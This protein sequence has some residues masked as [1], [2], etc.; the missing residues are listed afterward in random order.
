MG[1]LSGPPAKRGN[2]WTVRRL[3]GLE[4]LEWT[5]VSCTLRPP[6]MDSLPPRSYSGFEIVIPAPLGKICNPDDEDWAEFEGLSELE[7]RL[8]N[9]AAFEMRGG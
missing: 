1:V 6:P 9:D 8:A 3:H 5:S 2:T 7:V 4:A